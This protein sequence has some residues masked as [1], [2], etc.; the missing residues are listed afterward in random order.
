MRTFPL[1]CPAGTAAAGWAAG[2]TLTRGCPTATVVPAAACKAVTVPANGTGTSTAA[3]AVSTSTTAWS[4]ATR[5]PTWTRHSMISASSRPSPRSGSRKSGTGTVR[6]QPPAVG[7]VIPLQAG[8]GVEDAVGAGQVVSL[9]HG[10]RVGDVEAGDAQDGRLQ[11]VEAAFGEPGRDLGAVAAEPGRLVDDDRPAGPP[12]RL[13]QGAVVDRGQAAQVDDLGVP[14]FLGRRGRGVQGRRHRAAVADQGHVG[15]R[16]DHR[17][18][19]EA[20]PGGAEGGSLLRPVAA[21]GLQEDDR[22]RAVNGLP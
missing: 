22:V 2:S 16:L 10:S 17:G 13:G 8:D 11:V 19:V 18:L 5:S 7:F 21:L 14:A 15:A 12:D 6:A 20:G 3:L 4:I 9:Q 1:P